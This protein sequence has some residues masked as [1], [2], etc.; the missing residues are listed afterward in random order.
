MSVARTSG[1]VPKR[2]YFL[3]LG[4]AASVLLLSA[5]SAEAGRCANDGL[6]SRAG[7]AFIK[8]ARSRSSAAFAR[9]LRSYADLRG[10]S[11]YA[12]GKHRR[13][14]PRGQRNRFA[15]L[16]GTYLA[17]K[18][19]GYSGRF[20]ATSLQIVRCRGAIV[21][22]R[23]LQSGGRPAR[24]VSWRIARGRVA[25]VKVQNIWLA[26]L[27]RSNYASII[28]KGDG[29]ID[30]LLAVLAGNRGRVATSNR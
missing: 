19:A 10:I 3:A 24:K 1:G 20:Q 11:V 18:L 2:P 30:V 22:T 21:E 23:L 29:D 28:R 7:S 12:L 5:P 25:D 4:V 8:A 6:V 26:Q 9:A 15:R 16:T 27:L 13:S 14:L 17:R